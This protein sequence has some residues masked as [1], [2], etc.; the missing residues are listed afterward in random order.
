MQLM[1]AGCVSAAETWDRRAIRSKRRVEFREQKKTGLVLVAVRAPRL[2]ANCL[3]DALQVRITIF[4]ASCHCKSRHSLALPLPLA[5][6]LLYKA[7]MAA[8]RRERREAQYAGHDCGG[9]QLDARS[10]SLEQHVPRASCPARA[11]A[12]A[13]QL[14][15]LACTALCNCA[16]APAAGCSRKVPCFVFCQ[17]STGFL[18]FLKR[19]LKN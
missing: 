2:S 5:L 12:H 11:A 16:R 9:K 10:A 15:Q 19:S 17:D 3:T 4:V 8:P 13:Q 6:A 18:A 7:P 1:C 14:Q